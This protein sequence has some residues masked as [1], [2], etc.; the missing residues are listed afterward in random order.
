MHLERSSR[1]AA[2]FAYAGVQSGDKVVLASR[3]CTGGRD[4][5]DD[6]VVPS[7]LPEMLQQPYFQTARLTP[8]DTRQ[9]VTRSRAESP[10]HFTNRH[11]VPLGER[12]QQ[13]AGNDK[14]Q[15]CQ[16]ALHVGGEGVIVRKAA[17]LRVV[18]EDNFHV[19]GVEELRAA[20]ARP[21]VEVAV[22]VPFAS[23]I[24]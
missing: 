20:E 7:L 21:L 2:G 19:A 15:Q 22:G 8:N 12:L 6:R 13:A 18:G 17:E 9:G 10:R 24:P 5:V 11:P 3:L 4:D 1:I 16:R 14:F 23:L